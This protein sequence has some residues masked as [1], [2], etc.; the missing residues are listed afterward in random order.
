LLTK[1][2]QEVSRLEQQQGRRP[3]EPLRAG[4]RV[5][6]RGV[7]ELTTALEG[8]LVEERIKGEVSN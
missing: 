5:I 1:D 8:L 6:T 3:V 2:D 4:E 7:V